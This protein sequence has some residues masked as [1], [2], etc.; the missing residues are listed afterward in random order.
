MPK[1]FVRNRTAYHQDRSISVERV[2]T[3]RAKITGLRKTCGIRMVAVGQTQVEMHA[4]KPRNQ[5]QSTVKFEYS[6]IYLLEPAREFDMHSG[7]RRHLWGPILAVVAI[8]GSTGLKNIQAQDG[9]E[10]QQ[11]SL[12]QPV[13]DDERVPR[14]P[15]D[16]Y[17]TQDALGRTITF[18]LSEEP[19]EDPLPLV[20]Y[21]Q[22]SGCGSLFAKRGETDPEVAV[23]GQAGHSTFA[24][25]VRGRA[26]LLIIEKPG[27]SYLDEAGEVRQ[28]SE[29]FAKNI[30]SIAGAKPW[31]LR[32][33]LPAN[34]RASMANA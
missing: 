7:S 32:S 23:A 12:Y 5:Q 2:L 8:V 28:A 30:L 31:A 15:Y 21:V 26:R 29:S 22:G 27:V 20:V 11:P 25:V 34:C 33:K 24:D 13:A 3:S 6:K 18:Y 1:G 9:A 19:A 14:Q 4:E 17:F 16:R 10:A